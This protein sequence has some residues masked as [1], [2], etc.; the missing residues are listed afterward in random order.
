VFVGVRERVRTSE[1]ESDSQSESEREREGKTACTRVLVCVDGV[2]MY[3]CVY[4]CLRSR[5]YL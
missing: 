2:Q 3:V 1:S 4:V 5:V